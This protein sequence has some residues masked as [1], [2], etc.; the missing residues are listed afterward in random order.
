MLTPPSQPPRAIL[1]CLRSLHTYLIPASLIAPTLLHST[2]P[3]LISSSTPLFLRSNFHIDPVITPTSYSLC[4][5]AA[6]VVDLFVTLPFETVLRRGQIGYAA[7]MANPGAD[8]G[9][10]RYAEAGG[11]KGGHR[12]MSSTISNLSVQSNISTASTI[13]A[14]APL[15]TVV[16]VG[17]YTGVWSTMYRIVREEGGPPPPPPSPHHSRLN[18]LTPA[19][20]PRD[21]RA[22]YQN[23]TPVGKRGQVQ[24]EKGGKKRG[25]G[26]GVAGLWRGWRVGMW[27][28]IGVWGAAAMGSASGKGGEF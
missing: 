17:P 8:L 12:R 24:G 2:L 4:T 11:K 10:D 27:G 23:Q 6:S 16:D 20:T 9:G 21:K 28:L 7:A 26:Q 3:T 5:F 18:S 14:G 15:A 1:P 13:A 25:Q 19:G 22:L